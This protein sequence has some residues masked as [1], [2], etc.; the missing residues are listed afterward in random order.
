VKEII[1][2][3]NIEEAFAQLD[4]GG[5]F[6]NLFTKAKDEEINTAELA[7]VA[8]LFSEKQQLILFLE[9]SISQLSKQDQVTIISKLDDKLRK[10][11]LKYKA[12]ELMPS[13]AEQRGVLSANA[14]ITGVPRVKNST[15]EFKGFILIPVSAGKVITVMPIP[16]IDQYDIYEIRDEHAAESF[17][18]AHYRGKGTLPEKKIKVAGVLK[19]IEVET[20]G[21]IAH[22]KFLEI[23]YYQ[24]L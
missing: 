20:E 23:N 14:I 19:D 8:G 18:V 24:L 5:R 6:Y 12:Q 21:G 3:Q 9:L 22:R 10:D 16:I 7:R 11:F 13:E 15:S 2:Y 1:S 17:L 4:N